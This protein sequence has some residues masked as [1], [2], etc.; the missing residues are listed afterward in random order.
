MALSE[1]FERPDASLVLYSFMYADGAK[2]C[3]MCT[4]F[5]DSFD[6][7]VPHVRQRLNVAVVARGSIGQVSGFAE[8]RGW[9]HL[10]MLS[11]ANNSYHADYLSES[12]DGAQIPMVNV[13]RRDGDTIRHCYATEMFFA[14]N[15]PG[16]HP[17]HVDSIFPMWNV[18]D[19]TPEG[20]PA[21]WFP[22]LSYDGE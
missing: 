1:L 2:A 7:V 20:R 10:R 19:L 15:E 12:P 17:R 9:E 11:S 21:D 18:F 3:P 14:P 16:M 13:F 8:Q 5:L 6:R 22:Q 4:S